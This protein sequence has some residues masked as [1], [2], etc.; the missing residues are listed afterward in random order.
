MIKNRRYV[1]EDFEKVHKFLTDT[2][3][4]ETL[5]S[6]LLPQFFEYSYAYPAF[7]YLK[8]HHP[9]LWEDGGK[10]VGIVCFDIGAGSHYLHTHKDYKYLLPELLIWA[11]RELSIIKD[12][13]L[14]SEVWITENEHDKRELIKKSGYSL[15]LKK[16]VNIFDYA[17]PIK[18]RDLP[19]D[20]LFINGTDADYI[21]LYAC[22]RQ[23]FGS[24]FFEYDISH[25]DLEHYFTR[26]IFSFSSPHVDLSLITIA[27]APNDEYACALGIRVDKTNKYAYL[28]PL[29]TVPKYRRMGLASACINQAIRKTKALG[30]EYCFLGSQ[31]FYESIG[32]KSIM[33]SELWG[34]AWE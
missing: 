27:V 5:N 1:P 20:F 29:A 6:L 28:E 33:Q 24:G 16:P 10:I 15:K 19:G 34:K 17:E 25:G 32:C 18:R 4:R 7:Q 11:E 3:D 31:E 8:S 30:A 23:V 22:F 14:E 26:V 21:K 2:Y 9:G 13:M 12:D